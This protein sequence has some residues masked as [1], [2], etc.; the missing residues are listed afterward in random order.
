VTLRIL[1]SGRHLRQQVDP[2]GQLP[3]EHEQVWVH[4]TNGDGMGDD[5]LECESCQYVVTLRD[6]FSALMMP[7]GLRLP[8]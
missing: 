6:L 4:I 8:T 1:E 3:C 2:F 5:L 7:P